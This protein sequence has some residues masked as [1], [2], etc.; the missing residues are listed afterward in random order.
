MEHG[1]SM[2]HSSMH[3]GSESEVFE[4]LTEE[5]KKKVAVMKMDIKIQMMEMK[6]N[7]MGKMIELKKKI[8]ADMKLVQ[9]MIKHGK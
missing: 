4:F 9:E 7:D 3:C 6:I 5:Q 8:I 1:Q 2:E